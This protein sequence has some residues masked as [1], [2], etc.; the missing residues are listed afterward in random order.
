MALEVLW[1]FITMGVMNGVP[2][3]LQLN[4]FIFCSIR[5]MC[6]TILFIVLSQKFQGIH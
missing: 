3:L 5:E 6:E 2:G 4:I 1:L